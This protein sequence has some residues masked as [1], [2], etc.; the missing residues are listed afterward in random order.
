MTSF[1]LG[2]CARNKTLKLV[3]KRETGLCEGCQVEGSVQRFI[4]RCMRHNLMD[5]GSQTERH[6]DTGNT[7]VRLDY[8]LT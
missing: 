8:L 4:V 1:R 5:E 2:H 3:E 6:T 7:S